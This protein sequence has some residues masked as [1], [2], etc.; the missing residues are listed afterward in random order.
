MK[1]VYLGMTADIIHPGIINIINNKPE[2]TNSNNKGFAASEKPTPDLYRTDEEI[3]SLKQP[4]P[5]PV[6][7]SSKLSKSNLT[8]TKSQPKRIPSKVEKSCS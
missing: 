2:E 6:F 3:R 4:V 8:S 1:K 7:L 5:Y